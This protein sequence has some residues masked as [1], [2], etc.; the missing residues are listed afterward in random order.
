MD[1]FCLW[2]ADW[3]LALV[4]YLVS[5]LCLLPLASIIAARRLGS[6]LRRADRHRRQG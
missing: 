5:L 3:R 4:G 1:L 6:R 2:W